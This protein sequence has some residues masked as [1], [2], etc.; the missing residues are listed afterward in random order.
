[1]GKALGAGFIVLLVLV[2]MAYFFMGSNPRQPTTQQVNP[3]DGARALSPRDEHREIPAPSE[4]VTNTYQLSGRLPTL[5]NSDAALFKHLSMLLSS[6]RL[7]LLKDDQFLRKFVL[8]IDN[9][10]R[11][12][13][14]Y[15]HSPIVGPK[16]RFEV[17]QNGGNLYVDK[18]NYERYNA[19]ADLAASIDTQLLVAFYQFYEPL[20]DEAYAE[21]GYPE[22]SFRGALIQAV[23]QAL[24]TPV[25]EGEIEI[26]Q[27]EAN[28]TY[29]DEAL[30]SL[31]GV[32]KQL[33]R[34]GP[35]NIQKIQS[36]LLAFKARIQ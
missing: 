2:A 28:Y 7:S 34:M 20:L 27:L 12:R 29:T 21:L 16:A 13:L 23:D 4:E 6:V 35:A 5:E 32:Q 17:D 30:E 19:Y 1:M 9:A 15:Q 33:L 11:G 36:A 8:Q 25:I 18:S 10:S 24:A 31:N 3:S 14:V 22:G 26:K